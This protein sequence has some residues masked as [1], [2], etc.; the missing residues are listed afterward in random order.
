M[1]DATQVKVCQ[2]FNIHSL[3]DHQ[4][5][6]LEKILIERK[7]SLIILPTGMGKSLC[8]EALTV[9]NNLLS[10]NSERDIVLLISPLKFL[11]DLQTSR[12]NNLG[13]PAISLGQKMLEVEFLMETL[14]HVMSRLFSVALVS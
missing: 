8:F 14:V 1:D 7:D 13:L 10:M 5:S 3:K 12:L 9:T 4:K 11:M 2:F 6:T